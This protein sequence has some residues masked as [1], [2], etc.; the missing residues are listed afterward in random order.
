MGLAHKSR[1]KVTLHA[2]HICMDV[3]TGDDDDD[4][5]DDIDWPC[6]PH[7]GP[8]IHRQLMRKLE[9]N[10]S[11]T[12][13]AHCKDV[14]SFYDVPKEKIAIR[15]VTSLGAKHP[16]ALVFRVTD[17]PIPHSILKKLNEC[18]WVKSCYVSISERVCQ[19]KVV[20]Q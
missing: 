9:R 10:V 3:Q 2:P 15:C 20:V 4:E 13:I 16:V 18:P 5:E 14:I 8:V 11:Q 12:R 19:F 1:A 6:V 17:F 7:D